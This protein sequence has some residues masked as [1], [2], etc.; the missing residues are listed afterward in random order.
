MIYLAK[1]E[2]AV[3][4]HADKASMMELDG[5]TPEMEVAEAD[6]QAAE[7]LA[8][9]INGKIFLGRTDEE[10]AAL[11]REEEITALK[12]RLDEIDRDSGAGRSL[13]KTALNMGEALEKAG[14]FDFAD[15]FDLR[16]IAEWENEAA[17]IRE[18]LRSL[19]KAQGRR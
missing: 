11:K 2:G 7:G 10:K 5:V 3:V 9:I 16:K 15:D 6:W 18:K 13:R 14:T 17:S 1:K 19:E 12:A 8:R 4:A